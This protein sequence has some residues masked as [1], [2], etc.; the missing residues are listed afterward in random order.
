MFDEI[1]TD[2]SSKNYTEW[3]TEKFLIY[4]NKNTRVILVIISG[5]YM[6]S[7]DIN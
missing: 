2:S 7:Q 3:I 5:Y 1:S 6:L 4:S